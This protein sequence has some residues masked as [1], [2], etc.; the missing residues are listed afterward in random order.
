MTSL[1]AAPVQDER[2]QEILSDD[3]LAFLAELHERFDGRRLE[4]LE[5]R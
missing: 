3:A 4:L 5:A 2:A 1:D